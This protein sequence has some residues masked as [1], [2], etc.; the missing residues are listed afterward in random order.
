MTA[1][2]TN[3]P[4]KRFGQNYIHDNNILNNIISEFS[5]KI[6]DNILEIGP[7]RGSLTKLLLEKV[8]NLTAVEIDT[9]VIENLQ[10]LSPSL[11]LINDDFLNIELISIFK[12]T[13]KKIRIIGN[14]PYNITS[15][16]IFKLIDNH[17]LVSDAV[18]M[19]QHEVA[20]RMTGKKGTK[21]YGIF[22]IILNYFCEVKYCFK[23]SRNVFIPKPNV[24]SAVVRLQFKKNSETEEL[25]KIFI[26][27]VKAS[28][29]NRRKM[30][31]NSL[32]NSIFNTIDFNKCKIDLTK[33]AE[34]L[35]ITDFLIMSKFILINQK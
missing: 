2:K 4:L 33:R 6:G 9:R 35:D 20:N 10:S 23:V 16:I 1:T 15:P 34:D 5:P 7:G 3:K 13:D 14:I 12:L 17:N 26:K 24:D 19:V 8:E 32:S 25:Q 22:S 31:R 27:T 21:N 11:N 30:L 28:F 29:G 18:L